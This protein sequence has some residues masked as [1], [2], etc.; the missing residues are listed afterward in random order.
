MAPPTRGRVILLDHPPTAPGRGVQDAGINATLASTPA[1]LDEAHD[2]RIVHLDD[3]GH[4]ANLEQPPRF[5]AIL[6]AFLDDVEQR[7][8]DRGPVRR[9]AAPV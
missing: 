5:N 3:A 1:A 4:F 7:L 8:D 2:A 9:R 6:D